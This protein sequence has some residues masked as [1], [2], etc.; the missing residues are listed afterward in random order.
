[1]FPTIIPKQVLVF[2]YLLYKSFENTVVKREIAL[3]S[4]YCSVFFTLLENFSSNLKLL[5]ANSVSFEE[6]KIYGLGRSYFT[7][8]SASVDVFLN[9]F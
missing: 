6:S 7:A 2:M 9:F 1:M 8:T 5:S 3:F 4:F